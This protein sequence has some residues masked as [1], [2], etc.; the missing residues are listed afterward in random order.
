MRSYA[1]NFGLAQLGSA[2]RAAG[3][4]PAVSERCSF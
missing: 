4:I 2:H 3:T 1:N